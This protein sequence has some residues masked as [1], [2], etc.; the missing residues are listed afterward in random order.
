MLHL[1]CAPDGTIPWPELEGEGRVVIAYFYGSNIHPRA[2]WE[3]RCGAV[4]TLAERMRGTA[5]IGD[6]APDDWF[7]AMRGYEDCP[8]GGERCA[9][10]FEAQL[11]AAADRAVSEG[12]DA[13]CTTLTIS[14]HKDPA[15]INAIGERCAASR[16]L[17]W[18][19]RVWRRRD[20]FKRSVAASREMGLYRQNWCG[21]AYS[22]RGDAA[23]G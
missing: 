20:G 3:A 2:E 7:A 12:C 11:R 18:V 4:R 23:R 14:P 22:L 9:R 8:E 6:Y 1:C 15:L 21:C 10:C 13:L 19:E 5:I 16:G 17:A